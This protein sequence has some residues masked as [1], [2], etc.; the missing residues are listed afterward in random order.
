MCAYSQRTTNSGHQIH[1]IVNSQQ[2]NHQH[3]NSSSRSNLTVKPLP[4]VPD[5]NY[6]KPRR[7]DPYA[8]PP[9]DNF[10]YQP[11]HIP[12]PPLTPPFSSRKTHNS[13]NSHSAPPTPPKPIKPSHSVPLI[14]PTYT[15]Q[16]LMFSNNSNNSNNN[17]YETYSHYN[18]LPPKQVSSAYPNNQIMKN[19]N[20]KPPH[21]YSQDSFMVPKR[22]SSASESNNNN[23]NNNN[24]LKPT[25]LAPSVASCG[26]LQIKRNIHHHNS[27]GLQSSSNSSVVSS[28]SITNNNSNSNQFHNSSNRF[29][30]ASIRDLPPPEPFCTDPQTKLSMLYS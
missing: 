29:K 9:P 25:T 30:F 8:E 22:W 28:N 18:K 1:Y 5:R 3:S 20:T 12:P 10:N 11:R 17:Q 23:N 14:T 16:Q 19:H 6:L 13:N 27:V 21:A 2:S 26:T 4:E 15:K 7:V 24:Y